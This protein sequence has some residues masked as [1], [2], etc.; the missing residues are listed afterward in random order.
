MLKKSMTNVG[1][2]YEK[3][4]KISLSYKTGYGLVLK[5]GSVKIYL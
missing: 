3:M 2:I 1:V 5:R 4:G